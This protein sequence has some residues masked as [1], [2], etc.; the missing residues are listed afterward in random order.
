MNYNAVT[1]TPQNTNF[2]AQLGY[3]L[4]IKKAPH[5]NFFA[6]EIRIPSMTIPATYQPNP[7]ANIPIS[8]EHI[9][10]EPLNLEFVVDAELLNY[11]EIYHWL[12]G[13]GKPESYRQYRE[14]MNVPL[15]T[16]EGLESDIGVHVLS[17]TEVPKYEFVFRHAFPTYLGG[18]VL[19][20]TYDD[21]Q[22]AT[23]QA[24]FAYAVFDVKITADNWG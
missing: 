14:L 19:R 17:S 8:G 20:S 5:V 11:F 10:Y 9:T 13:L 18:F 23:C 15:V 24:S 21:V 4:Y 2:L 7:M 12:R 22:Y 16:G 3:K 6:Q 1:N